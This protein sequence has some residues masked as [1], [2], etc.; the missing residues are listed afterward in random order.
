[1]IENVLNQVLFLPAAGALLL[2]FVPRRF[3]RVFFPS[4]ALVATITFILSTVLYIDFDTGSG[5]YQFVNRAPWIASYNITYFVGI[6]GISLALI[7]LTTFLTAIS[8]FLSAWSVRERRKEFVICLL[9]LETAMVGTFAALDVFLFYVFWELVLIPMYLL[10]G[11]FGGPKRIYA[12]LKFFIFTMSGSVLMLVGLLALYWLHHVEFGTYSTSLPDLYRLTISGDLQLWLFAGFVIAFAIKIPMF[13]FHTWLP[14]AHTEA[15]T[16]GSVLLAG[17]LLK[18]G[19]YGMIRYALPLFPS[20]AVAF[21]PLLGSLGVIAIL[22]GAY[23]AMA[24]EDLKKLVA[25][26]SVSHMGFVVLGIASLTSLGIQGA[27]FQMVAHG[28]ST[29]ALFLLVGILYERRHTRMLADFGGLARVTPRFAAAFLIITLASI[30][31]PGL[32]GFVGEFLILCGSFG[33]TALGYPV[34]MVGFSVIGVVL[35]AVY[36]LMTYERIFWGE[37]RLEENRK[38]PDLRGPE[39]L[40]LILPIVAAVWL[41]VAPNTLLRSIAPSV[42]QILSHIEAANTSVLNGKGHP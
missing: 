11:I 20:A 2:L 9:V 32:C 34:W 15:P 13:P 42:K 26:S 21:A 1:M 19:G 25:Y 24:Q 31:L 17:V 5:A 8:L 14:D 27:V 36:M 3:E 33:G 22:Y 38:L 23:V 37:V 6:D 40:A 39:A 12:T 41:G 10:I 7:L 35:G 18:M 16:A 28:I 4:A 29:G 30:G